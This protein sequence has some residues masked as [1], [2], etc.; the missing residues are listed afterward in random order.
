[1]INQN[2]V[3]GNGAGLDFSTNLPTP[4]SGFAMNTGEG[5]ASISDANGNLLFY[6]DG[7]T[8]WDSSHFIQRSG[9]LG[10]SSSTQSAII[11]PDPGN[12]LQYYIFTMD[13]TSN[14]V[15]PN[16]FNGGLIRVGT[17][18]VTWPFTPL[19]SLMTLPST[20]GFSPAE[21]ITAIQH[22]NCKDYWVITILQEGNDVPGGLVNNGRGHF[23][24]FLVCASGVI[25][26]NTI[27]MNVF[28]HE[29]GYLKG[30]PNGKL[31]AMANGSNNNVLVYPFDNATGVINT[32]GLITIP[33]PTIAGLD[34][35]VYGVE[36]AP[37]NTNLLY[38]GNLAQGTG[39]G[40][41]FQ[42]NLPGTTSTNVGTIPNGG[43][44]PAGTTVTY[45]IGA[46][47][48]GLD[49]RIYIAKPDENSLA[50]IQ[51]PDV[52]GTGCMVTPNFIPLPNAICRLGLPN[53]IP[54]PCEDDCD[55][56]CHG[57][58]E[59]ADGNEDK[60]SKLA[61]AKTFVIPGSSNT[62]PPCSRRPYSQTECLPAL[63]NKKLAL[64]FYL[65][66]GDGPSDQIE[67]HDD[68]ILYLTVCNNYADLQFVG[69]RITKITII[70]IRPLNEIR[71]IP[72]CF[73]HFDCVDPCTCKS[74]EFALITREPL[75]T[76][77]YT[78]EVEYCVDGIAVK[79]SLSG[80]T[81][82]PITAVAS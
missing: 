56:K 43:V 22:A 64:C 30:S 40:F 37:N 11:V 52:L 8:V 17:P 62:S 61:Q 6:T 9:L 58:D 4:L 63:V 75:P 3:F 46:L 48:L 28:V 60:L 68:E 70:P 49:N 26:F 66:W 80:K 81:S 69:L 79:A 7:I 74:R 1:M 31:L 5:C 44:P 77:P 32:G 71:I 47:Q 65:H 82:F 29:L 50:A 39:Q 76:G 42:V 45:A 36:F 73:V 25:H 20:A 10:D 18:G 35:R 24:I 51:F 33:V 53:L 16:H 14:P 21:K 23:R 59:H 12:K 41:I 13:G 57:C 15:V 19:S 54:N 72:D 67:T 55:C 34:R 38:Y 78:I 27:P 2:W